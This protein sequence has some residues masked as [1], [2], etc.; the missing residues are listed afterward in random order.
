MLIAEG[1]ELGTANATNDVVMATII[2]MS[3]KSTSIVSTNIKGVAFIQSM[4]EWL[5]KIRSG[6]PILSLFA[7]SFSCTQPQRKVSWPE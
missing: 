5:S 2:L 3:T 1:K 4:D 7:G 6:Q